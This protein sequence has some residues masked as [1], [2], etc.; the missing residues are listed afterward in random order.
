MDKHDDKWVAREAPVG[1]ETS[2]MFLFQHREKWFPAGGPED[3]Q[4]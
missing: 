1:A 2:Q 4:H 3:G